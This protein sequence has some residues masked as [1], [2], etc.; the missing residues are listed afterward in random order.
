MFNSLTGDVY[1]IEPIFLKRNGMRQVL[2]YAGD[3]NVAAAVGRLNDAY[4]GR[5]LGIFPYDWNTTSFHVGTGM[6][7]PGKYRKPLSAAFPFVD[8][9][10]DYMG[11]GVVLYWLEPN[12]YALVLFGKPI[13]GIVPN[14]KLLRPSN[15]VPSDLPFQPAYAI[16]LSLTCGVTLIVVGGAII[17]VTII[18]D[19]TLVGLVDDIVTVPGGIL[20][21]NYGTKLATFSPVP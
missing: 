6:D 5:Y 2:G 13:A 14:R 12:A 19:A 3:L 17:A 15:W 11:D 16:D 9:V 4:N 10:A 7:W 20:L 1:E 8:L 21:I 18:E